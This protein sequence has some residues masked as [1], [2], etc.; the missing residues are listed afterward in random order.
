MDAL[1]ATTWAAEETGAEGAKRTTTTVEEEEVACARNGAGSRIQRL[2]AE[3]VAGAR[4][5]SSCRGRALLFRRAKAGLHLAL[6][7]TFSCAL[8]LTVSSPE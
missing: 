1:R 3:A 7:W 6:A 4:R 2:R 5:P 8:C